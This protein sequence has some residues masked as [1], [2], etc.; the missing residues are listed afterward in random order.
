MIKKG[1]KIYSIIYGVCPKCHCESMY[2]NNNPYIFGSIFKMKERCSNCQTKYKIEP[3]FFYGAMYVSYA[4]G[5]AIALT[6]FI[7]AKLF[8]NLSFKTSMA[9]I[10]LAIVLTYPLQLRLARNIWINFYIHY[11]KDKAH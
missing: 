10:V 4:I 5:V 11:S 8:F 1:K 3:A 2:I 9:L 7:I 6:T